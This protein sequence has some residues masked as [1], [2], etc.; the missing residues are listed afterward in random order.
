MN[1][2]TSRVL[3]FVFDRVTKVTWVL[4]YLESLGFQAGPA[5]LVCLEGFS[6]EVAWKL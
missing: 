6:M 4:G 3:V 2:Y 1:E 5:Y